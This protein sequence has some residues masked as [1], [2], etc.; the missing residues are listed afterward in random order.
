MADGNNLEE[1]R[2]LVDFLKANGIAEFEMDRGE[3]KRSVKMYLCDG[4][5]VGSVTIPPNKAIPP[6]GQIIEVRYL[7][8]HD[9]GG[10]L[11]QAVYLGPRADVNKEDCTAA[12]LRVKGK[13]KE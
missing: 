12:Q 11:V 5:E 1:L 2:E 13:A 4:T 10:D 3:Q 8:R 9:V 6:K 7:Y